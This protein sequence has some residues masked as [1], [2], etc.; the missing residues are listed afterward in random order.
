MF[1]VVVEEVDV[2]CPWAPAYATGAPGHGKGDLTT[3]EL[4]GTQRND[5]STTEVEVAV[6]DRFLGE[7]ER[8]RVRRAAH[9]LREVTVGV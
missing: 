1:F 4:R 2:T 3:V 7:V 9:G 5:R 8:A 6:T